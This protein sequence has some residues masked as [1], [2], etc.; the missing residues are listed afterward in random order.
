MFPAQQKTSM[1]MNQIM[2]LPWACNQAWNLSGNISTNL[3][4]DLCCRTLSASLAYHHTTMNV[5]PGEVEDATQ[6]VRKKAIKVHQVH[7][8]TELP[9]NLIARRKAKPK[10]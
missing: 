7:A 2:D 8:L 1:T 9:V 5:A 10:Y 6:P 4:L 3:C